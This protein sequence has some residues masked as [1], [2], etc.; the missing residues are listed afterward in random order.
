MVLM[1]GPS[2]IARALACAWAQKSG[3]HQFLLLRDVLSVSDGISLTSSAA[4]AKLSELSLPSRGDQKKVDS[5][6]RRSPVLVGITRF[7]AYF[8]SANA[9]RSRQSK[10]RL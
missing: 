2:S 10:A 3:R 6:L 5:R 7:K 4:S 9:Y 8:D 1:N